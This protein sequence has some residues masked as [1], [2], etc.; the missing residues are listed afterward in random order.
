MRKFPAIFILI[1]SMFPVLA[2]AVKV[3]GVDVQIPNRIAKPVTCPN[4]R[5][6]TDF[7]MFGGAILSGLSLTNIRVRNNNGVDAEVSIQRYISHPT[8]GNFSV[9]FL[10][11]F[12]FQINLPHPHRSGITVDTIS[13]YIFGQ[14]W[15]N[16][17]TP[18]S[19]LKAKCQQIERE[20]SS[21]NNTSGSAGGGGGFNFV[22]AAGFFNFSLGNFFWGG[23]SSGT[24]IFT[25]TGFPPGTPIGKMRP[26]LTM[27]GQ[28]GGCN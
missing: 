6:F 17:R 2:Y 21:A 20:T 3:C 7:S 16:R 26:C 9:D 14:R 5:T 22:G 1:S 27:P 24:P 25:T 8:G 19:S 28:D 4:C 11:R 12:G 15:D 10:R 13:G 23:A 18:D